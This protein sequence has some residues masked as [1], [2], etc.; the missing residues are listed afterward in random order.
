MDM[1]I[2]TEYFD[3]N[4]LQRILRTEFEFT[5]KNAETIIEQLVH[6]DKETIDNTLAHVR[7]RYAAGQIKNVQAYTAAA[8]KDCYGQISQAE[9]MQ[10]Q[11]ALPMVD[12][13]ESH[14]HPTWQKVRK[15]M[16]KLIGDNI[17]RSWIY[18]LSY[19]RIDQGC[20]LLKATSTFVADW[21]LRNYHQNLLEFWQEDMPE[22]SDVKIKADKGAQ[23]A[24]YL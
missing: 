17:Y 14:L 9:Q 18:G 13:D 12:E 6:V 11:I 23:A 3:L 19:E 10:Q 5:P 8:L 21:V 4:E 20:V 7:M 24:S 16:R 1:E 15:A 22:V 2:E